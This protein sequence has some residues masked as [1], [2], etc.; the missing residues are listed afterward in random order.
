VQDLR[1]GSEAR[2][3][4][5]IARLIIIGARAVGRLVTEY[6]SSTDRQLQL[7]ILR[8]LEA[9]GD[10]RAMDVAGR[11]LQAGGDLAMGGVAILRD[12]LGRDNGQLQAEAL[13]RLL[14]VAADESIERR[15]RAS[16]AEALET[17]PV[18]IRA[19]LHGKLPAAPAADDAIWA[20]AGDGHLPD[21][22]ETLRAALE[23]HAAVTSL[24]VLRRLIE[25]V[26]ERERQQPPSRAEAWRTLRGALHQAIASRDS[27]VALYDLR[28]SFES[29]CDPLP[30]SF[31]AAVQMIGDETCLDAL[32]AAY[33]RTPRQQERWRLQLIQAFYAVAR[34]ERLTRKHPAMRRALAR[35]G[36]VPA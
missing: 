3:E 4:A 32:A 11:A 27:R 18:D 10:G 20:D 21:N 16:A 19:I 13:D 17:L 28:E 8:V 30:S 34:R 33:C 24:P 1:G 7:S 29:A 9:A 23:S 36:P 35:I 31:L 26:R 15:V 22:P 2:R 25:A 5:A 14:A 12:L 6:Q